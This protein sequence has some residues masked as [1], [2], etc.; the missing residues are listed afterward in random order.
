[1]SNLPAFLLFDLD[2]TILNFDGVSEMCWRKLCQTYAPQLEGMPAEKL[3]AAIQAART[4]YWADPIRHRRGRLDLVASRREIVAMAF[5]QAGANDPRLSQAMADAYTEQREEL[6]HPFEGAIESLRRFQA[7]GIRMG[8]VTNGNATFQ[9]KKIERFQLAQFFQIILIEGEFGVGKPDQ[10]IFQHALDVLQA[11]CSQ[12]WMVGNDLEYDIRPAL[13]LGMGAVWVDC[14]NSGLPPGS[15]VIP[16]RT[17]TS[18]AE[19]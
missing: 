5:E 18:L 12:A 6:V 7:Q 15:S 2:D 17:I 8:L 4:W 13:E 9:R 10:R 11:S 19:L 14:A 16:T 1:L 3:M